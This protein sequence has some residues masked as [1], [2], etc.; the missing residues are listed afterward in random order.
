[1]EVEETLQSFLTVEGESIVMEVTTGES[2]VLG[3]GSVSVGE[4]EVAGSGCVGDGVEGP[5]SVV[6]GSSGGGVG[7]KVAPVTRVVS[8][9]SKDT[10]GKAEVQDEG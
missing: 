9:S 2:E 4:D 1:M 7:A 6:A 3:R 10:F 8:K 5:S